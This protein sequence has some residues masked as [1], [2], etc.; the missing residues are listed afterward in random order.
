M[1]GLNKTRSG[2]KS[3]VFGW[4]K[5]S[6]GIWVS[7]RQKVPAVPHHTKFGKKRK[8]LFRQGNNL[9]A[10]EVRISILFNLKK[11]EKITITKHQSFGMQVFSF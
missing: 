10:A 9:T 1:F 8:G 6:D 4:C 5:C 3:A 2:V 11:R 7:H